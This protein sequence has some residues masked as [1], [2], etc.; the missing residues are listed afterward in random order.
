[1]N[2]YSVVQFCDDS[3]RVGE[4]LGCERSKFVAIFFMAGEWE[5]L[6]AKAHKLNAVFVI[7]AQKFDQVARIGE[8]QCFHKCLPSRHIRWLFTVRAI[9]RGVWRLFWVL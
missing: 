1:M 3:T 2:G 4:D 8:A 6:A 9:L 5:H 7:P